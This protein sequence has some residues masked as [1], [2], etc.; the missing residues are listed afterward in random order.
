MV[1]RRVDTAMST[2]D[3]IFKSPLLKVAC[4][5]CKEDI[6]CDDMPMHWK[7]VHSSGSHNKVECRL[8]NESLSPSFMRKH[9]KTQHNLSDLDISHS[10][11]Q[12]CDFKGETRLVRK[13]HVEKEHGGK[14]VGCEMCPHSVRVHV[15]RVHL[16]IRDKKCPHCDYAAFTSNKLDVHIRTV[17]EKRKDFICPECEMRL[18]SAQ[19]VVKHLKAIHHKVRDLKCTVCDFSCSISSAL[20]MHMRNIHEKKPEKTIPCPEYPFLARYHTT[21]KTHLSRVHEKDY[22]KVKCPLCNYRTAYN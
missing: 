3:K 22:D 18:G 11:C 7:T 8:C 12:L 19:S 13:S 10:K 16:N 21:L 15:R 1:R 6:T 5:F 17:H 9:L 2:Q 20:R 14:R 4:H